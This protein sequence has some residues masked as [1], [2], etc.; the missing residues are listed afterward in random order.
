MTDLAR[1]AAETLWTGIGRREFMR[2]VAA[3]GAGA[4]VAGVAAACSSEAAMPAQ[5]P[6]STAASFSI[7]QPGE[8]DPV[9]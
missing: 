5:T 9:G 2:A 8:G 6:S 7:L 4:G 3:V 1:Q